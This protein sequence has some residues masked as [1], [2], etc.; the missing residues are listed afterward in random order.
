MSSNHED[1]GVEGWTVY[2][3]L[4]LAELE[5]ISGQVTR[6]ET[7]LD[8]FRIDEVQKIRQEFN[9]KIQAIKQEVNDRV[10]AVR[11]DVTALKVKAGVAGFLAG[12]GGSVVVGLAVYFITKH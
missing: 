10:Q 2:R 12:L 3:K 7:K 1:T 9:D 11:D 6:V 5:R 4:I 8:D